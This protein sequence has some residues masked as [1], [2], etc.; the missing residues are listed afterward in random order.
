MEMFSFKSNATIKL[1]TTKGE[2]EVPVFNIYKRSESRHFG[3]C[4]EENVIYYGQETTSDGICFK[5]IKIKNLESV[6]ENGIPK[7]KA[8]LKYAPMNFYKKD[9]ENTVRFSK[10]DTFGYDEVHINSAFKFSWNDAKFSMQD[11]NDFSER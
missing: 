7:F 5:F 4:C 10:K 9:C 11:I 3:F 1:I 2:M 6:K 8:C